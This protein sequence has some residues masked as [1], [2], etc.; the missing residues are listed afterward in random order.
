MAATSTSHRSTRRARA[1]GI[2]SMTERQLS[3][4]LTARETLR[5][6]RAAGLLASGTPPGQAPDKR[7]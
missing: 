6:L 4:Y 2:P 3:A 5:R 1:R 7:P